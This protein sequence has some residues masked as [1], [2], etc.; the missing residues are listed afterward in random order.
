MLLLIFCCQGGL[1]GQKPTGF[2]TAAPTQGTSFNFGPSQ[3]QQQPGAL[4]AATTGGL[5]GAKSA[6]SNTGFNFGQSTNTGFTGEAV[7]NHSDGF[8]KQ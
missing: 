8:V 6:A 7:Q 1:F 3:Q 5:F 2:G 4:G